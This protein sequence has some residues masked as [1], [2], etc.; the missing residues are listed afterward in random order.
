MVAINDNLLENKC[1]TPT[2][3]KKT[4]KNLIFR[5]K[6]KQTRVFSTIKCLTYHK[7]M[8]LKDIFW[9]VIR[10]DILHYRQIL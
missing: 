9:N 4:T 3:H 1:I 8:S 6:C 5:R 2:Q 7:N 10:L